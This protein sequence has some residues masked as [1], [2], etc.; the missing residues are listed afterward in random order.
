M[1][2][3]TGGSVQPGASLDMIATAKTS[4]AVARNR[5]PAVSGIQ[6]LYINVQ[7]YCKARLL[8]IP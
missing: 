7:Q 6:S 5:T 4:A 3:W 1:Q 8:S 2:Q